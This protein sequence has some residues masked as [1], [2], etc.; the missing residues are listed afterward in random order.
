MYV[1]E[2]DE[3][4]TYSAVVVSSVGNRGLKLNVISEFCSIMRPRRLLAVGEQQR[5][6]LLLGLGTG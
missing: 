6:R 5:D 1:D 4:G 2:D 3:A